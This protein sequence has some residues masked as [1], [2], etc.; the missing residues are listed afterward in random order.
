MSSIYT[1]GTYAMGTGS[2]PFTSYPAYKPHNQFS[3]MFSKVYDR[4]IR[5]KYE[6]ECGHYY[7][8]ADGTMIHGSSVA[9]APSHTMWTTSSNPPPIH[10]QQQA[11]TAIY[12][13]N[14]AAAQSQQ[15]AH[16]KINTALWNVY[17]GLTS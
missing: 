15:I 16:G 13:A 17:N 14:Q 3:R 9:S 8:V 6:K 10:I 5:V 11:M 7:S 1:S 4:I 2:A 12:E